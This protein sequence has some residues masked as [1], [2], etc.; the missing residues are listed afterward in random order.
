M[1]CPGQDTQYW[2]PG[3]IYEVKCPECGRRVEFFKDDTT[4]RCAHCGHRF[5]NPRLDFGCAAYCP[6]AEQCIGTLPAE[7]LAQQE[8]LLKDRVAVEV[9]RHFRSD[10]ARI[11]RTTRLAR[12]AERIAKDENASLPV[13]LVAAYLS[14][15]GKSPGDATVARQ[16]LERLGAKEALVTAVGEVIQALGADGRT[17]DAT[18]DV[19][20]DARRIVALEDARRDGSAA[21]DETAGGWATTAGRR[22]ADEILSRAG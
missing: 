12:H 5:V 2:K 6:F 20:Q 11:G 13:V 17:A 21:A 1:K 16:I 18:L 4:R 15:T 10:F 14:E 19:L 22:L 3:A 8:N 7:A 9:K